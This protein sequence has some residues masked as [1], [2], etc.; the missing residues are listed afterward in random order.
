MV[1]ENLLMEWLLV[2]FVPSVTLLLGE[3]FAEA[4]KEVNLIWAILL[5][6]VVGLLYFAELYSLVIR[7][8]E[9]FGVKI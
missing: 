2:I 8:L 7:T 9:K 6:V 1:K 4:L 5:I 3:A